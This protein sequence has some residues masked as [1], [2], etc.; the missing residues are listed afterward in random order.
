[1]Y[2]NVKPTEKTNYRPINLLSNTSKTYERL[3]HDN[4]SDYFNG[5]LSKFQCDFRRSFGAQYFLLYMM[6]IIRKSFGAQYFLLYMIEI[7]RKGFCA[8]YFLLYMIEIIRK[9]FG[10]QYF[11]LHMIEI[12]QKPRNNHGVFSAAMTALSKDFDCIFHEI[13][14]VW[15]NAY[16]FDKT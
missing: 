10:A 6:E 14:I 2:Q 9:G 4:M 7:I 13:L 8:Q 16:S 12:I 3:M 11:L 15:L 5:F 1:M